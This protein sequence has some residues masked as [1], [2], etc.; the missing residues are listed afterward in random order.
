MKID[1]KNINSLINR[2]INTVDNIAN[3]YKYHIN[4]KHVL[5]IIIPAFIIK[6]GLENES[7]ILKLFKDTEIIINENNIDNTETAFFYRNIL[8]KHNNYIIDKKVVLNKFNQVPTIELIDSL[9]H[10]FNHAINSINNEVNIDNNHIYLRSG[11]LYTKYNKENLTIIDSQQDY[12]ILEEILNTIQ[13]EEIINIILSLNKYSAN[14]DNHEIS[15]ILYALNKEI[16]NKYSSKAYFLQTYLSKELLRN[17]TFE[18]TL[19]SLRLS[20]NIINIE[21]WFDDITG[22][23]NSYKIL[24]Q[25]LTNIHN[26]EIKYN[27]TKYFKQRILNNIK[28]NFTDISIIIEKFN[29]NCIYK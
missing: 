29:D 2:Y 1:D 9:I 13:T 27:K 15:N 14:I 10:E 12:I 4:I 22:K 16:G 11:I 19:N 17:R 5:Y 26:L 25:K 18:K 20:D 6:Y 8:K 24:C 3:Q 28:S 21:K 7:K 23:N